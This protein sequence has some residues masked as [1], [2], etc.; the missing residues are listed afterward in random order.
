MSELREECFKCLNNQNCL[1]MADYGSLYC[2][3]RRKFKMPEHEED[4]VYATKFAAMQKQIDD[5]NKRIKELENK[6]KDINAYILTNGIDE[7]LKT[8]TQIQVENQQQYIIQEKFNFLEKKLENSIPKQKVKDVL[9]DIYDYFE[10]L[11]LPDEDIEYIESKR[12]E[13]LEEGE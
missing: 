11:N 4:S 5:K 2:M 12:K 10:R 3:T 1:S 9:D 7:H 6:L 8:A 13:L